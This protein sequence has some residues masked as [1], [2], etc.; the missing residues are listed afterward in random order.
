MSMILNPYRYAA[1]APS[2]PFGLASRDFDGI[3]D[4]V[5]TSYSGILGTSAHSICGW[6]KT[7]DVRTG[8]NNVL[9]SYGLTSA[10]GHALSVYT[11]GGALA[12][13][14]HG[15]VAYGGSNLNDGE[16]CHFAI[17]VPS[18]SNV[19]NLTIYVNGSSISLTTVRT[20]AINI[21]EGSAVNIGRY[22]FLANRHFDGNLADIRLYSRAI[23][24]SEAADLAAGTDI[25][26]TG[27]EGWWLLNNDDVLDYS[28]NSRDG[29]N[30]GSTYSTDGPLD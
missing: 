14:Y 12:A 19:T 11:T 3:N 5:E 18:A 6:F 29:T 7:L 9:M 15:T 17:S 24:S 10:R 25:D 30:Y 8:T 13:D 21:Q 20:D 1:A 22:V 26:D 27:L 2:S 23:T 28:G 4:Y 16:W